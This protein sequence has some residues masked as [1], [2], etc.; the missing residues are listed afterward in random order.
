MCLGSFFVGYFYPISTNPNLSAN[1]YDLKSNKTQILSRQ[2]IVRRLFEVFK[3]FNS[4]E[5][6]SGIQKLSAGHYFLC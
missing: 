3:L 2:K 6:S 4:S 5:N 1:F